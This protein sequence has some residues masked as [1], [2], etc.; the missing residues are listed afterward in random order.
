MSSKKHNK[1]NIIKI[2]KLSF[3]KLIFDKIPFNFEFNYP[4]HRIKVIN[5]TKEIK[6]DLDVI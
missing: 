6:F 5:E 3:P 2:D 4:D 1:G